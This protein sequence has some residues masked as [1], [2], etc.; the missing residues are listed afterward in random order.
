MDT[1]VDYRT[2]KLRQVMLV[3]EDRVIQIDNR[4]ESLAKIHGIQ[5]ETTWGAP[6]LKKVKAEVHRLLAEYDQANGEKVILV[7]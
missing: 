3:D 5:K 7:G 1:L 2:K 6:K 4:I